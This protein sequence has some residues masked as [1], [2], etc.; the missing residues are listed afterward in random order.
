MNRI[1]HS[2]WGLPAGSLLLLLGLLAVYHPGFMTNDSVAQLLEARSGIFSDGHPPFMAWMWRGIE[3]FVTGA[4]GML[5]VQLSL[6]CGGSLLLVQEIPFSS[7]RQRLFAMAASVLWPPVFSI[8]GA[9]WKDNL[10]LGFA[11]VAL[12]LAAR[13]QRFDAATPAAVRI[14]T[15]SGAV[16]CLIAVCAV[17]YNGVGIALSISLFAAFGALRAIGPRTLVLGFAIAAVAAGGAQLLNRKLAAVQSNV[18]GN[19][20]LFDVVGTLIHAER[21]DPRVSSRFD[22]LRRIAAR[23]ANPTLQDLEVLYSPRNL[24][25]LTL[26]GF[27]V[28]QAGRPGPVAPPGDADGIAALRALWFRVVTEFPSAY[29]VHRSRVF[30]ELIGATQRELSSPSNFVPVNL[31]PPG[32]GEKLEGELGRQSELQKILQW[33]L[34]MLAN[35]GM[36]R[37]VVYLVLGLALLVWAVCSRVDARLRPLYVTLL[38]GGL[39][40]EAILFLVAPAC[41]YRYSNYLVY[42]VSLVVIVAATRALAERPAQGHRAGSPR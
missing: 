42:S 35:L 13:I 27:S 3:F 12:A 37:P 8:L 32:L 19:L 25:S 10:M 20:A 36:H 30:G 6:V 34:Q 38:G 33:R 15:W 14:A 4:F 2:Q 7:M 28:N 21:S 41:D 16:G 40:H 22:E 17:R 1:S 29:L 9:I 11:I 23:D 24:M 18:I 26:Q 39:L 31:V 5:L